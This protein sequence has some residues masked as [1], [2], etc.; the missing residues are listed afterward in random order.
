MRKLSDLA[1]TQAHLCINSSQDEGNWAKQIET[2]Q[3]SYAGPLII[4][5]LVN[6]LIYAGIL[7]MPT[8]GNFV[9]KWPALVDSDRARD[10]GIAAT[11]AEALTKIGAEIDPVIFAETYFPDLP[12]GAVKRAPQPPQQPLGIVAP[13]GQQDATQL[14]QQGTGGQPDAEPENGG[15]PVAN[16]GARFRGPV[17]FVAGEERP[18]QYP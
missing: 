18:V 13:E 6:R 10:A 16:T 15:E 11:V 7:P 8:T 3:Q 5:P 17:W 9:I 2:R 14:P 12:R 4:R 1:E